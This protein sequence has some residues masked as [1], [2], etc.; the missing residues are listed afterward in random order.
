[1]TQ[2]DFFFVVIVLFRRGDVM[3]RIP[4]QETGK[5]RDHKKG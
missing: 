5:C 4:Q 2:M 1:M 3:N